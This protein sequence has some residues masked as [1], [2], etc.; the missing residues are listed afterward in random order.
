MFPVDAV[1]RQ[2]GHIAGS[3]FSADGLGEAAAKMPVH[4]YCLALAVEAAHTHADSVHHRVQQLF[5]VLGGREQVPEVRF[6]FLQQAPLH[7]DAVG[8]P[9]RGERDR[10]QDHRQERRPDEGR[11]GKRGAEDGRRHCDAEDGG[12]NGHG[13]TCAAQAHGQPYDRENKQEA[14]DVEV[15]AA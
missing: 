9:E 11:A 8:N 1:D 15:L 5:A 12:K 10:P 7:G 3:W 13:N 4:Q 14:Q 6:L 2:A